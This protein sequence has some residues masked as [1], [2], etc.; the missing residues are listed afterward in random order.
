MD[1]NFVLK[2]LSQ[3]GKKMGLSRD[4]L[5]A[6]ETALN[7][8][9]QIEMIKSLLRKRCSLEENASALSQKDQEKLASLGTRPLNIVKF[10]RSFE[11]WKSLVALWN[12]LKEKNLVS[13]EHLPNVPMREQAAIVRK[14]M[15]E[16]QNEIVLVK[17][18]DLKSKNITRLPPEM[19]LFTSLEDLK[20]DHNPLYRISAKLLR[21]WVNLKSFS[22]AHASIQKLP[23]GFG[24][25]WLLL[26]SLTLPGN[27][28]KKL[29]D[30]FTL[31][32]P[33]L[34]YIKLENNNLEILPENFG[35]G[36]T[37][38]ERV[39]IQ[40]NNYKTLPPSVLELRGRLQIFKHDA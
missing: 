37:D 24:D 35:N 25:K 21:A 29:P 22:M 19:A 8:H 34:K 15:K 36:W 12:T 32:W 14:R 39:T 9:E 33:R 4:V 23:E 27:N 11:G 17:T 7:S 38:L 26:E 2:R 5:L 3:A 10:L 13:G 20:L 1:S 30:H 28:L 18:L 6:S 31:R 40:N 16:H